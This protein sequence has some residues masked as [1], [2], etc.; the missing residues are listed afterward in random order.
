MLRLSFRIGR[1]QEVRIDERDRRQLARRGI[2]E[3]VLH[4]EHG[5]PPPSRSEREAATLLTH[6]GGLSFRGEAAL[7][8]SHLRALW[9]GV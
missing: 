4:G 2:G 6:W 7:Y 9:V 1:L 5:I 3:E 8:L